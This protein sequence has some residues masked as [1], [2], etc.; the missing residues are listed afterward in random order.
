MTL[1]AHSRAYL[2]KNFRL[3]RTVFGCVCLCLFHMIKHGNVLLE[4]CFE[5]REREGSLEMNKTAH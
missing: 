3:D 2:G 5:E 1:I 4:Y